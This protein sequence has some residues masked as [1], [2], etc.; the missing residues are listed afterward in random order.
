LNLGPGEFT[1][2]VWIY[3]ERSGVIVSKGNGFGSRDQWSFGLTNARDNIVLRINNQ[4]FATAPGSVKNLQW[5][6]VAF[7]RQG[8][9]GRFYVD[10]LSNGGPHDLS[11]VGPLVNDRP[12][13]IGRRE[14]APNPMYFKGCVSGLT[15]WPRALSPEQLRVEASRQPSS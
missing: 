14:H 4:F 2:A 7:V 12:L 13:R 3:R 5:T 11:A 10:G 9:L 6:H 8:K 1:L 15:I